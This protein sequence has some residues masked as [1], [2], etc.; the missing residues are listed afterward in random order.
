MATG[1][2]GTYSVSS[3]QPG[4]YRVFAFAS[5]VPGGYVNE[6]YPDI[7]CAGFPAYG[8]NYCSLATGG[9]V[10]VT[11]G[12]DSSG[13]DFDLAV[14]GSIVGNVRLAG[15]ASGGSSVQT[16]VDA[17][18]SDALYRTTATTD[19]SGAYVLSS[20]P[21]GTYYVWAGNVTGGVASGYVPELSDDV[22]CP[23]SASAIPVSAPGCSLAAATPVTVAAGAAIVVNFDLAVGGAITGRTFSGGVPR[24]FGV[25]A[26]SSGNAA[27]GNAVGSLV[28]GRY[29]IRGLP[30]GQ[31]TTIAGGAGYT[32]EFD[33]TPRTVT[34]GVIA[35]GPDF[36]LSPGGFPFVLT[37]PASRQVLSGQSVGLSVTAVGGAPLSYQWYRGQ[38]GDVSNPV[39][40][41]TLPDF[42]T[43]AIVA[44]ADY[45]AR[46]SNPSGSWDSQAASL[47]LASAG[48]G[49]ISG[50]ITSGGQPVAN[51]VVTVFSNSEQVSGWAAPTNAS[52]AFS[53]AGLV[54]GTYYAYAGAGAVFGNVTGGQSPVT[55]AD[56]PYADVL[57]PNIPCIGGPT[58]S[59]P[60]TYC[61]VSSGTL[62]TVTA[63]TATAGINF[64]LPVGG[65]VTGALTLGGTIP[66][67]A[68]GSDVT[69][70]VDAPGDSRVVAH[71]HVDPIG[72]LVLGRLPAGQYR[73]AASA[74]GTYSEVWDDVQC[75]AGD[76]VSAGGSPVTVSLGLT[77]GGKD[78]DLAPQAP[79][80]LTQPRSQVIDPGQTAAL[81]VQVTGFQP[82]T[83]QW[84]LGASGDTATPLAGATGPGFT[85][86]PLTANTPYWVRV[87]NVG[88]TA[89][90]ATATVAVSPGAYGGLVGSSG[91]GVITGG[92]IIG[93][94]ANPK[95]GQLPSRPGGPGTG[96]AAVPPSGPSGASRPQRPS[97]R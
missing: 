34:P 32:T 88:G 53:V 39:T 30:P 26:T 84:Y 20:L 33:S 97:G 54:P 58:N 82:V 35:V 25:S 23:R 83:Y 7:Q 42:T 64:D 41:A 19:A 86:A 68:S 75:P 28:T 81:S 31:Y 43:P 6:L 9:L 93:P 72:T 71:G 67:P 17:G 47:S 94:N 91:G 69:V 77:T 3:L 92:G 18:L 78:F 63:D 80:I 96:P 51:A 95:P 36:D 8:G 44:P 37:S 70:I 73:V 62:I 52:G 15:V 21:A 60:A 1:P 56:Y 11:A 89:D 79:L 2:G 29:V 49:A 24:A 66:G 90:S 4:G 10:A 22:P 50:T 45:W 5:N 38:S 87:S 46:V 59:G 13:I 48:T 12:S 85:T 74:A 27:E 76:C 14:G 57:Y 61:R 65:V 55:S 16:H 40:G